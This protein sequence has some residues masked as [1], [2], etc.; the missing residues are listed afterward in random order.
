MSGVGGPD[1]MA[2]H[3]PDGEPRTAADVISQDEVAALLDGVRSGAVPTD[4]GR[5][6]AGPVRPYDFVAESQAGAGAVAVLDL[7]DERVARGLRTALERLL[8]RAV[9]VECGALER[10]R[11]G[12][13][14]N[15]IVAPVAAFV[16][17]LRSFGVPALLVVD[18][19]LAGAATDAFYG[20]PGRH[21]PRGGEGDL[22]P[23]EWRLARRCADAGLAQL[24][25]AWS[26]VSPFEAE[27]VR[28]EHDPRLLAALPPG[29]PVLVRRYP[30]RLESVGEIVVVV[31]SAAIDGV[32]ERLQSAGPSAASA[33]W[34][35]DLEEALAESRVEIETV[36]AKVEISLRA[37][38]GL[39]PGD[40]LEIDRPDTVLVLAD[41][42]P[43]FNA[44]YGTSSG[45]NA[46]QLIGA[47]RR[48]DPG[49][50]N[51]AR[52]TG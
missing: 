22:T 42:R 50:G 43:L 9:E 21:V 46:V 28:T 7:I 8:S 49:A 39:R 14:V 18:A 29:E 38:V 3:E 26:T 37:L 19:A 6:P 34:R 4:S 13:F 27:V 30:V 31:P 17:E 10:R 12:E 5:N 33:N 52:R 24:R 45:R 11:Y 48:N 36:F 1:D 40:V 20:G 44:R 32:R 47:A 25:E 2:A 15:T 35:H 41:G 23:A 51:R 16:L